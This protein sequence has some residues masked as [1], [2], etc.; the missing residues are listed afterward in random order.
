M[1]VALAALLAAT[2]PDVALLLAPAA[3][4]LAALLLGFSPGE[5]LIERMRRGA[6]RRAP[7]VRRAPSPCVPLSSSCGA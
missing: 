1:L 4:L 6:S 7:N 2:L 3:L 5:R